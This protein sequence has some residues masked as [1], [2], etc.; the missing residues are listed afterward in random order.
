MNSDYK[1]ILKLCVITLF[2]MIFSWLVSYY[3]NHDQD[4]QR[5]LFSQAFMSSWEKIT[6]QNIHYIIE[7][8][9]VNNHQ[10]E[11]SV[12]LISPKHWSRVLKDFSQI[13][14]VEESSLLTEQLEKEF[15]HEKPAFFVQTHDA[16]LKFSLG[17]INL[18]T[19]NFWL[20]EENMTTKVTKF[21]LC[22]SEIYFEGFYQTDL[23][24]E[25][26]SYKRFE[27]YFTQ[28]F[29]SWYGD[30]F[31]Q[32]A[33]MI[34]LKTKKNTLFSLDIKAKSMTPQPP[35]EIEIQQS[36]FQQYINTILLWKPDSIEFLSSSEVQNKISPHDF[37]LEIVLLDKTV[38]HMQLTDRGFLWLD[39]G[40]FF[41]ASKSFLDQIV[42]LPDNFYAR[43]ILF[44]E[45]LRQLLQEDA[46]ASFEWHN[47]KLKKQ[48]K[49]T[50]AMI[51][52]HNSWQSFLCLL[53]N[54]LT[55]QQPPLLKTKQLLA[56]EVAM[57]IK[58][59][60][61]KLVFQQKS[62]Y[63]QHTPYKL[64]VLS[65]D[66]NEYNFINSM[67]EIYPKDIKF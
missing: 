2:L 47:I 57:W 32:K 21:F 65:S 19:G 12:F 34:S 40:I 56:A 36:F 50:Y 46:S 23:E 49:L 5:L 58:S 60:D 28:P 63:F 1:D 9:K 3:K 55:D 18:S 42:M 45:K 22:R 43:K 37:I 13:Y 16:Q 7:V 53:A 8:D 62:Y 59:A 10:Q 14:V 39:R 30:N 66:G 11:K 29:K 48:V 25:Q 26:L 17:D 54:C 31:W 4:H 20:K 38:M 6:A 27:N 61:Y 44:F 67:K 15:E 52:Q 41:P 33:T 51:S 64:Q 24:G 35:P